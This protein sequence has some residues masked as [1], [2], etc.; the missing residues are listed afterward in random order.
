MHLKFKLYPFIAWVDFQEYDGVELPDDRNVTDISNI[1][2]LQISPKMLGED[3][4]T[5]EILQNP[6]YGIDLENESTHTKIVEP[7]KIVSNL[8]YV[9]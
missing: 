3:S 4:T 2:K 8:Y 1:A 6:Y 5:I 7:I 9:K